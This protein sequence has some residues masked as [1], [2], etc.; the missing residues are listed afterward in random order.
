MQCLVLSKNLIMKVSF[1]P[2]QAW[3]SSEKWIYY[4]YF[5][6]IY[7]S[8]EESS[9]EESEEEQDNEDSQKSDS[10][11][12]VKNSNSETNDGVKV[13]T[14]KS[15]DSP[16]ENCGEKSNTDDRNVQS[17]LNK[18]TLNDDWMLKFVQ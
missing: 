9:E 4:L 16:V 14:E 5:Q 13:L 11:P 15:N 7:S 18:L 8:E 3:G 1:P 2:L 10:D 12:E 6:S 17:N